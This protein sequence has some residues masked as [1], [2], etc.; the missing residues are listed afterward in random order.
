M[1]KETDVSK[2]DDLSK[3]LAK[4]PSIKDL[5]TISRLELLRNDNNNDNFQPP[6]Q[7][8]PQPPQPPRQHNFFQPQAPLPQTSRQIIF[9]D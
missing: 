5:E 9:L 4:T 3:L 1:I 2:K 7:S 8:P 6:L